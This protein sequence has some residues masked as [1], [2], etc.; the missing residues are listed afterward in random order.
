MSSMGGFYGCCVALLRFRLGVE[1]VR[2]N[3]IS[4]GV[5][6]QFHGKNLEFRH[7]GIKVCTAT[8]ISSKD[9]QET[10]LT[11]FAVPYPVQHT[12]PN[13]RFFETLYGLVWGRS[14]QP[15]L[16]AKGGASRVEYN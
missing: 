5:Q 1:G 2:E 14:A 15:L 12:G 4:V 10:M 9:R 13:F 7:C 8:G 3:Y 6:T 11:A 16:A